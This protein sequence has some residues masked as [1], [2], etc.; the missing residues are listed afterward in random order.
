MIWNINLFAFFGK[1]HIRYKGSGEWGMINLFMVKMITKITCNLF[2]FH[3]LYAPGHEFL[4]VVKIYD[5]PF[6]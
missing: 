1:L 5:W 4:E 6:L 2:N 3:I